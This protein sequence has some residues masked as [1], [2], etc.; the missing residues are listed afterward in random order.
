M[1]GLVCCRDAVDESL[2]TEAEWD[3]IEDVDNNHLLPYQ[4]AF[5]A[6]C[7]A[8]QDKVVTEYYGRLHARSDL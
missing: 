6:V 8:A 2:L 7:L 5:D 1:I 3:L 4:W